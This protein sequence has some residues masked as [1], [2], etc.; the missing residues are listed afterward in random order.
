MQSL[1]DIVEGLADRVV[2]CTS[3]RVV[4]ETTA[5]RVAALNNKLTDHGY[6]GLRGEYQP[7][8]ST[9]YVSADTPDAKQSPQIGLWP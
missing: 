9:W 5:E 2:L 4:L 6:S 1:E 3:D 7:K 8:T